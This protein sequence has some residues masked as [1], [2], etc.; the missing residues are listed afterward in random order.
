MVFVTLR[1]D[2]A[3]P[4]EALADVA[5]RW[6]EVQATHESYLLNM[7]HSVLTLPRLLVYMFCLLKSLW[8]G[9]LDVT[10]YEIEQGKKLLVGLQQGIQIADLRRFLSEQPDVL[11][12]EWN[13][14]TY[15]NSDTQQQQKKART[16]RTKD[17]RASAT[18]PKKKRKQA[19]ETS[20]VQEV[21]K[22]EL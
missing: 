13:S 1:E 20:T 14:N 7:T 3:K 15:T 10:V 12:F 22:S 6:K 9:G 16:A 17:K 18:N 8:N 5:S 11:E 19:T 4:Q 2:R 21:P